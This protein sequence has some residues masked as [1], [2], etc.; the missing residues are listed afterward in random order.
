MSKRVTKERSAWFAVWTYGQ[1]S[2][3]VM[4]EDGLRDPEY[5]EFL[6]LVA[7]DG[8]LTK[9]GDI[10]RKGWD[11]LG[12]DI[13]I[14][15]R[16]V[17]AWMRKVFLSAVDHGHDA[18]DALVGEVRFDANDIDQAWRIHEGKQNNFP[19]I[20]MEDNAWKG[21]SSFG[22]WAIDGAVSFDPDADTCRDVERTVDRWQ[23]AQRKRRD[24]R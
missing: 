9:Q 13:G 7:A 19:F 21:T 17:L 12:N 10:T 4:V 5:A 23:K 6:A 11:V 8:L 22:M 24:R 16:N 14:V 2:I 20:D 15:E 3:E 18:V 1:S